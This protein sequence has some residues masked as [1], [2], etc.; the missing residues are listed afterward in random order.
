MKGCI[1]F[2]FVVLCIFEMGAQELDYNLNIGLSGF[3]S[4]DESGLLPFYFHSN[5]IGEV[6]NTSNF[7]SY[8]NNTIS[9]QSKVFQLSLGVGYFIDDASAYSDVMNKELYV[10]L[11]YEN[12]YFVIGR[13]QQE[14]LFNNISVSNNN[15]AWSLNSRP[16]PGIQFGFFEPVYFDNNHKFGFSLYW[17]EFL[18]EKERFTSNAKVHNKGFRLIYDSWDN[19]SVT[20]GLQHYAQWGGESSNA[21]YGS[22]PSGFKDYLRVVAGRE[23]GANAINGEQQNVIGNHLGIYELLVSRE[24]KDYEFKFIYNHYIEDGSTT[25]F[26][27]FPDGRYGLFFEDGSG[28]ALFNSAMF[29]IFYTKNRS[30]RNPGPHGKEQYFN[31]GVFYR[32]GWTYYGRIIGVPFFDFSDSLGRI[33]NEEFI[34]Y[35]FG[36]EGNIDITK[37]KIPY[38]LLI[39][40][41]NYSSAYRSTESKINVL[42][43]Y[44][45]IGVFR[46]PFDLSISFGTEFSEG[47]TPIFAAGLS[48]S[49][50]FF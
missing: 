5:K 43:T 31:N 6:S 16:M 34:A 39:T 46:N 17:N 32:S 49:K 19:W 30:K 48:V 41:V 18:Q 8:L 2:L 26:S 3:K 14:V 10:E 11:D 36:L 33:V 20:V 45:D 21:E 28:N 23:G 27:N 4:S 1:P 47:D 24:F 29:E 50:S 12:L 37:N 9:Y 15:F 7:T 44:L 22:A 35:H 42:Y 25:R 40:N 13:K 38:R